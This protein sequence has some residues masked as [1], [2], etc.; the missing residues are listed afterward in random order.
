MAVATQLDLLTQIRDRLD[1]PTEGYWKN[2]ELLRWLNEATKDIARKSEVFRT[3][4]TISVTSGTQSYTLPTN[5]VTILENSTYFKP[6]STSQRYPLEPVDQ[7]IAVQTWGVNQAITRNRPQQYTT[8][9]YPGSSGSLSM[10]LYPTPNTNGTIYYTYAKVPTALATDGS[11]SGTTVDIPGGWEDVACDYV[12]Y[13]AQLRRGNYQAADIAKSNYEM[14]L[15]AMADA[16]M[17]LSHVP[18]QIGWDPWGHYDG[19]GYW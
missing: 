3:D 8:T 16:G 18:G 4:A 10:V 1:E 13:K 9:G 5:L 12:E 7:T 6:S 15:T 11:A 14:N 19:Y 2:A 17:R